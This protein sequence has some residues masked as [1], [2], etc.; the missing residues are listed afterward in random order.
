MAHGLDSQRLIFDWLNYQI[1]FI[2][3]DLCNVAFFGCFFVLV[4]EGIVNSYVGNP[5]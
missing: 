5:K 3:Y 4:F 2:V 1:K